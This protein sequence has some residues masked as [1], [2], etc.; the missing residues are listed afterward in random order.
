MA[1]KV[2]LSKDTIEIDLTGVTASDRR[3]KVVI[4]EGIYVAKVVSATGKKFGTGSQ[5]VEWI[6]EI[7]DAGKGKGARFWYNN[8]LKNADGE[9]MESSLW[10][11]RGVL[12]AL[13]PA[14]KI[15]DRMMKVPLGKMPGRTVAL[16]IADGEDDKG[17]PRSEIVDVFNEALIEDDDEDD[18]EDFDEAEDDDDLDSDVADEAE[19]DEEDDEFDLDEDEL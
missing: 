18:V 12:Q 16:E 10:S 5:G 4:P 1:N 14:V 11:F 7:T 13:S 19:D 9:T 2:K 15:P 6:F 8:T 3:R 17:K